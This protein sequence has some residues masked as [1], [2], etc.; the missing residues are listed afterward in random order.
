MLKKIIKMFKIG[1]EE[2]CNLEKSD[3]EKFV[4]RLPPTP[5]NLAMRNT[6]MILRLT[7]KK[8]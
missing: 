1:S 2:L 7:K 5:E 3:A 8:K 4:K 6:Y